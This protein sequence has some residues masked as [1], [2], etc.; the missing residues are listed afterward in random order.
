MKVTNY[1]VGAVL[2]ISGVAKILSFLGQASGIGVEGNAAT[3]TLIPRW[4]LLGMHLLSFAFI[5]VDVF[6]LKG[7]DYA[8]GRLLP[9]YPS[10]QLVVKVA[11]II[12]LVVLLIMSTIDLGINISV[13]GSML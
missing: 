4:G 7:V 6:I 2:L 11:A 5:A 1:L 12:L 9:R 10:G 8:A 13:W 3:A